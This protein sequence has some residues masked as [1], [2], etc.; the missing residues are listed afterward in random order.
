MTR[1]RPRCGTAAGPVTMAEAPPPPPPPKI[2]EA[3]FE[4]A[5]SQIAGS[6][7]GQAVTLMMQA[8]IA[9]ATIL[10]CLVGAAIF[11]TPEAE[12]P[13]LQTLLAAAIASLDPKVE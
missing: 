8:G 10:K 11:F 12:R 5:Q 7:L 9:R 1:R 2:D 6:Q 13:A 3:A 4:A